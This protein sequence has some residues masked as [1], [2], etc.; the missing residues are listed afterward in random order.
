MRTNTMLTIMIVF[1]VV[2][3][4]T[5]CGKQAKII[6]GGN[7]QQD[8]GQQQGQGAEGQLELNGEQIGITDLDTDGEGATLDE[9]DSLEND[10]DLLG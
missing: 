8:L 3:A 10:L 2:L 4:V 7:A 9:L 1:L 5:G 6:A